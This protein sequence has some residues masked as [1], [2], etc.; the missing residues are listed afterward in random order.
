M[1][2]KVS[3]R[4]TGIML[5]FVIFSTKLLTLPSLFY[6]RAQDKALFAVI[7]GLLIDF[8]SLIFVYKFIVNNKGKSLY[9][10]LKN[11]LTGIVAKIIYVCI[12]LFFFIKIV[13]II[14]GGFVYVRDS[15]FTQSDLFLFFIVFASIC[16]LLSYNTNKA[17]GRTCEFFFPLIFVLI[18]LCIFLGFQSDLLT[19]PKFD[20]FKPWGQILSSNLNLL[21]FFGDPLFLLLMCDR[22]EFDNKF[23]KNIFKYSG[24]AYISIFLIYF[25]FYGIYGETS[26]MHEFVLGDI[27]AFTFNVTD[28][29]RLDIIP[30][31]A[32]LFIFYI[33]G[34]IFFKC[35]FKSVK[36]ILGKEYKNWVYAIF[37]IVLV[38]TIFYLLNSIE[39][40]LYFTQSFFKWITLFLCII[41]PIVLLFFKTKKEKNLWLKN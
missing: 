29:G 33:Q 37:N 7:L 4:Q 25:L 39:K 5:F 28:L 35:C 30:V 14:N 21:V 23:K 36:E 41:L 24:F 12:F 15:V 18:L 2:E 11:K 27:I 22:I 3:T 31:V 26:I 40:T 9:E 8:L 16:N 10:V 32:I 20:I 13:F 1:H 38:I 17:L 34:S 6:Q 19:I